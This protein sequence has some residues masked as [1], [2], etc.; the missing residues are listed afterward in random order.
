MRLVMAMHSGGKSLQA[1][2]S[3]QTPKA[4]EDIDEW[5]TLAIT[6]GADPKIKDPEQLFR[7]PWGLRRNRDKKT[8]VLSPEKP[9]TMQEVYYLDKAPGLV[10]K[11]GS[12]C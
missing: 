6:I 3:P 12:S 1:W 7:Y 10:T 4:R 8:G 9:Y 5:V 11:G 2:Y